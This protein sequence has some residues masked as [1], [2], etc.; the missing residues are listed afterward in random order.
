VKASE[1]LAAHRDS[2]LLRVEGEEIVL[3]VQ[4]TTELDFS[5]MPSK[6]GLE[7]YKS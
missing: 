4:D 1:I 7:R 2:T 5:S 6:K 3:A